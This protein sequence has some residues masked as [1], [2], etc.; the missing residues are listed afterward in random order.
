MR[1]RALTRPLQMAEFRA[2]TPHIAA[3]RFCVVRRTRPPGLGNKKIVR[4][5]R[6]DALTPIDPAY[7][8][9]AA[10]AL[11][12][13]DGGQLPAVRADRMLPIGRGSSIRED[14]VLEGGQSWPQPP[15]RRPEPAE[16]R[17]RAELPAL[18]FEVRDAS[19]AV[20]QRAHELL[21]GGNLH[22]GT[23]APALG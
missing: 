10:L 17:L 5:L 8:D 11:F 1:C 22:R 3:S 15:F 12:C 14:L 18:H 19:L 20:P 9:K 21:A 16:S 7:L 6:L 13:S 2:D 4:E 23:H